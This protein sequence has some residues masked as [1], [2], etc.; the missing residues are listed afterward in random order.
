MLSR[1]NRNAAPIIVPPINGG[2]LFGSANGRATNGRNIFGQRRP[3]NL[4]STKQ[5][6]AKRIALARI[7]KLF[8]GF[9][10]I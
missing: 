1:Q 10:A 4:L 3:A 9:L 6:E 7:D 8:H 2:W 5:G